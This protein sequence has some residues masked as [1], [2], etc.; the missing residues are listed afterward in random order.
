M[1]TM[2]ETTAGIPTTESTAMM[3]P[4]E[5]IVPETMAAT[6]EAVMTMVMLAWFLQSIA[7]SSEA[8]TG[9]RLASMY[10]AD[11]LA[12]GVI[13]PSLVLSPSLFYE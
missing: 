6:A 8:P 3:D 10:Q 12:L 2:M 9:G 11:R 1:K 4:P 13:D 5:M 7:A